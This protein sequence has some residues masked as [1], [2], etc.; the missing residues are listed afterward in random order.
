MFI[1]VA[2]LPTASLSARLAKYGPLG[3]STLHVLVQGEGQGIVEGLKR[4]QF[5]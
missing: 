4:R 3:V 2:K 5:P 1:G